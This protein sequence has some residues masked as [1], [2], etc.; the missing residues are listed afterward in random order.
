MDSYRLEINMLEGDITLQDIYFRCFKRQIHIVLTGFSVLQKCHSTTDGTLGKAG[1]SFPNLD[2]EGALI[3]KF[4]K[5][6]FL[7]SLQH[8]N[9]LELTE[10]LECGC[11]HDIWKFLYWTWHN[12]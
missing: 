9:S 5:T 7:T 3:Y 1:K 12:C 8:L 10:L 2:L 11:N 6:R 4:S